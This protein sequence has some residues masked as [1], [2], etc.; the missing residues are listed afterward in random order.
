M[1]ILTIP[2]RNTW[3]KPSRTLLLLLVFTLGVMSIV[4][5]YQVSLV[6]GD[7]MEKK[8]STYGANILV[9]PKNET[10]SVRYGGLH[11]GDML[12]EVQPLSETDT[13][14]AVRSIELKERI[15]SV[16]PKLVT[17]TRIGETPVAVVGV[18]WDD[19]LPIKSYWVPEGRFPTAA[20]EIVAG[21]RAAEK[22][23]LAPG[24]AVTLLG[25]SFTVAAVL[26]P[27]GGDDDDVLLADLEA[28]QAATG[29]PDEVSFLE[30]AALCHGCPI[31][32]IVAQMRG[33][34]PGADIKALSNVVNQRMASIH[35]VQRLVLSISLVILVTAA[36]MVG[37]SMLSAVNERKK[38]IGLL[39]SLGYSK[40]R[41]FFIFCVE[42]GIIGILAGL[43]GYFSGYGASFK[44][45]SLLAMAEGARPL[46][47]LNHLLLTCAAIGT[48]TVAAA[49]YPAW[50]GA[51]VE[52]SRAL[53]AL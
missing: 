20:D 3:R 29:R 38:D 53:M 16:A 40:G 35:F 1:N 4:A 28:V 15:S 23:G 41:V 7:S 21:S 9:A 52:P 50:K 47:D 18:R 39:R 34:L 6:I 43:L 19:E 13:V 44:A 11:L 10:L 26:H 51:G 32:D 31:D 12:Y 49:A 17:T 45:L 42:A 33:M 22:F 30:V 36:T 5:L 27:T 8:L 14:A 25:R 37:L 46:F 2:L 24:D 48:V